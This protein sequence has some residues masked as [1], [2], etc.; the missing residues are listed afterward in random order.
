LTAANCSSVNNKA[1]VVV[2]AVVVVV[3][4]EAAVV[5]VPIKVDDEAVP[6]PAATAIAAFLSHPKTSRRLPVVGVGGVVAN[7]RTVVV[8]VSS[9]RVREYCCCC[10]N[11]EDMVVAGGGAKDR[12]V[13]SCSNNAS[14]TMIHSSCCNAMAD[15]VIPVKNTI[16]AAAAAAAHNV[17]ARERERREAHTVV[18]VA[19]QPRRHTG[20]ELERKDGWNDATRVTQVSIVENFSSPVSAKE[21]DVDGEESEC[22]TP[23]TLRGP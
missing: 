10:C 15:L 1:L 22:H 19:Q 2:V 7:K 4:A 3:A 11:D 8:V 5:V 14:A 20:D 17:C 21:L 23:T 12:V 6:N 9:R 13:G 16:M 18:D